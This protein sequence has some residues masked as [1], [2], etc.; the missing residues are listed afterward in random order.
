M[1]V[2][3]FL[4]SA[5]SAQ[6]KK[7]HTRPDLG[8][9]FSEVPA[10]TSGV[11]TRNL[12]KAAP[13]QIDLGR[14]VER[15]GRAVLVN[16]GNANACTGAA[17]LRDARKLS[18]KVS[19]TL[20]IPDSQVFLASTGVIGQRLPLPRMM[21][22][23]P[24][25]AHSLSPDGLPAVAQ[26][27]MT[28]DTF[29][30]L[31]SEEISVGRKKVRIVGMAKG[32]GMLHPDMATMLCFVLTDL[33]VSPAL[34]DR[35][36]RKATDQSFNRITVDGDTSTND[37]ILVMANGLAGN[38][39]LDQ[40]RT[41]GARLFS[42]ALDQVLFELARMCVRDGE[43]ATK[44]ITLQVQGARNEEEA[45]ILALTVAHSPLVKTALFGQDANWGRI[46]AALG[47]SGVS[48]DPERVDIYFDRVQIV[49]NGISKGPKEEVRAGAVLKKRSLTIRIDLHQGSAETRIYTCDLSLD[50]VRINA[51]YRT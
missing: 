40:P 50:Y 49:K 8:L 44:D 9:I 27:I 20:S 6:V 16:S 47:R 45:R 15:K 33:A 34:L 17:G 19:Q 12:V 18:L 26:A 35:F 29:P 36:L 39:V 4:A 28:T 42:S 32:A 2:P 31:V 30:K 23:V 10:V 37:L 3:G 24:A 7:G 51:D 11:F 41:N 14:I 43:G 22:A 13:V 38:P 5:V 48:F 25:L 21:K 1:Q 46:L